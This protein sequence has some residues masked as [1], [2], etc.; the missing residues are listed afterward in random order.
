MHI[1]EDN[2]VR[3]FYLPNTRT[4]ADFQLLSLIVRVATD[5]RWMFMYN[6]A[7]AVATRANE[8]R[9]AAATWL[10]NEIDQPA[11]TSQTQDSGPIEYRTPSASDDVI[12]IFRLAPPNERPAPR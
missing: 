6:A 10:F 3:V 5:I 12:R 11:N 7:R 8:E 4:V 9:L 2:V 1:T